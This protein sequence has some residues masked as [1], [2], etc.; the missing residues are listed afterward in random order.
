MQVHS[1]FPCQDFSDT[2]IIHL[3][4]QAPRDSKAEK[5][6]EQFGSLLQY[7]RFNFQS[8]VDVCVCGRPA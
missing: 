7:Q 3:W 5:E 4:V 1:H 2:G 6:W 8:S